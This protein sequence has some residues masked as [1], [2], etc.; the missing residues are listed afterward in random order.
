M[1]DLFDVG[2]IVFIIIIFVF[3]AIKNVMKQK[4]KMQQRPTIPRPPTSQSRPQTQRP[5][6]PKDTPAQVLQRELERMLGFEEEKPPPV[7]HQPGIPKPTPVRSPD[8]RYRI[9][10]PEPVKPASKPTE[11]EKPKPYKKIEKRP[12]TSKP[13]RQIVPAFPVGSLRERII[14]AEILGPPKAK[15]RKR[16]I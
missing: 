7:V 16:T 3:S 12:L 13:M 5:P 4:G 14:W 9:G 15:K 10:E 8:T 2:Y 1:E 6:Q 11:R